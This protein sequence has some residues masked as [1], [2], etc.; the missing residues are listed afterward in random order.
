[1]FKNR[2]LSSSF[3][4]FFLL[5]TLI[6]PAHLLRASEPWYEM[7]IHRSGG[8]SYKE[9]NTPDCYE[10]CLQDPQCMAYSTRRYDSSGGEFICSLLRNTYQTVENEYLVVGAKTS[11]F[12][13]TWEDNVCL[14]PDWSSNYEL[15]QTTEE[16]AHLACRIQCAGDGEC[17]GYSLLRPQFDNDPYRCRIATDTSQ[18]E[19]SES[20]LSGNKI[21]S[22]AVWSSDNYSVADSL[23]CA[24]RTSFSKGENTLALEIAYGGFEQ[25]VIS[26]RGSIWGFDDYGSY[27][28]LSSDGLKVA[29]RKCDTEGETIIESSCEI[30]LGDIVTGTIQQ[31]TNNTL[32]DSWP[33]ISADG[34][35][36]AFQRDNVLPNGITQH[37][38]YIVNSQGENERLLLGKNQFGRWPS[39]T[40]DGTEVY[41]SCYGNQEGLCAVKEDGTGLRIV[42]ETEDVDSYIGA[43]VVSTDGSMV[44]FYDG[45]GDNHV[46]Y[47]MVDSDGNGLTKLPN[48]DIPWQP[49]FEWSKPSISFDGSRIAYPCFV[50]EF[51]GGGDVLYDVCIAETAS[52]IVTSIRENGE[53]IFPTSMLRDVVLSGN[54]RKVIFSACTDSSSHMFL[55]SAQLQALE[56]EPMH[57]NLPPILF[58]LLSRQN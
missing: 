11:P 42:V 51:E 35:L 46:N 30:F 47:Y 55:S 45:Q 18:P 13:M 38:I 54:G 26:V 16:S 10:Q 17:R 50:N 8:Y 15:S 5:V 24:Y 14:G 25:G 1:M 53:G 41:F 19:T 44:A 23:T 27:P 52:G 39:I 20:C 33:S 21:R 22:N 57:N 32:M 48:R 31:L 34:S 58:L 49:G 37:R 36:I 12:Y 4:F 40:G 29:Y 7:D 28:A 3:C 2:S 6:A 43:P 56:N 9:L